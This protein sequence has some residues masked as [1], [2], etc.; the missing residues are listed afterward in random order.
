[1]LRGLGLLLVGRLE[2]GHE[3]E[4]DV[5]AVLLAHVEGELAD[6]LQERLAFDIAH[7]AADFGDD[8]IDV[9]AVGL[10][11]RGLDLVGDVRN[12]LHGL[13]EEFAPPLL[14]DHGK[15][16]LARGVVR[17]AVQRR[18]G[19]PLVVAQVEV[20][21]AAVVQHVDFAV[22]IGAHRARIDVDIGIELLHA[23]AEPALFQQHADRGAGQSL[24][25]RADH[26]A[27]NENMLAH[28]TSILVRGSVVRVTNHV[29]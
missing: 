8:D 7:R 14:V 29:F 12:D 19:E 2:V 5:K 23:D 3:R 16:D 27:G 11:Q 15:I 28:G 10:G 25:Q 13:A 9:G 1:M 21:F 20:G 22:L 24:A 6:G 18:V 17:V 4:V 26:P